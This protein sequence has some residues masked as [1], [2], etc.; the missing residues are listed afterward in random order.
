MTGGK[1]EGAFMSTADSLTKFT[2]FL[3]SL[4]CRDL[5]PQIDRLQG[6][7]E[8]WALCGALA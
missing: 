3:G 6:K 1:W 7:R 5:P 4:R 8:R 2:N